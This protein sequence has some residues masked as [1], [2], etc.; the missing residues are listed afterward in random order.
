[1]ASEFHPSSDVLFTASADRRLRLF[2]ING[3]T[4]P[5]L[6][7]LHVPELPLAKAK[8]HPSG[9]T[10]I[11]TGRSK[12]YYL[13]YNLQA[14]KI[15]RSAAHLRPTNSG[16]MLQREFKFSPDGSVLAAVGEGGHI[17]LIDHK[18]SSTIGDVKANGAVEGLCWAKGGLELISLGKD[19]QIYVWDVRMQRCVGRWADEGGFSGLGMAG[20]AR[21]QYVATRCASQPPATLSTLLNVLSAL[22]LVLSTCTRTKRRLAL[23]DQARLAIANHSKPSQTSQQRLLLY[24]STTTR[25]SLL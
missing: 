4:N 24:R 22:P 5:L 16:S 14:G 2:Q 7:S 17:H 20:D 15:T 1:M 12:P 8:F 3:H 6:Q 9:S 21:E 13:T 18:T 25:N 19:S 11:L 23:A 10:I